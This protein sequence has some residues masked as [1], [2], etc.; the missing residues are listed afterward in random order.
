MKIKDKFSGCLIGG[1]LGDALG[2]PIEFLEFNQIKLKYGKTGLEELVFDKET[3]KALISDDTQ[4][5]L[6]TASG[7]IWAKHRIY[8][9]GIGNYVARGLYPSYMRWLY[10]QDGVMRRPELMKEQAF[11]KKDVPLLMEVHEL[12]RCR[13]PGNTCISALKSGKCGS[14]DDYINNSK[15][16]GGVM[17]VAPVGLFLHD[18]DIERVNWVGADAAAIT[19]GH[20]TGFIT[21]GLFA[22]IIAR[23]VNGEALRTA[24]TNSFT[25]LHI[26]KDFEETE[27][28][29]KLALD[30]ADSD[31]PAEEAIQEIG[32][33]WIAEEALA[34]AL[35]CALKEE[36]P[37]KA[38]LLSVNH[39]GDS[40]STGA[41]CGNT[42]GA[43]HG[44]KAFPKDW[45]DNLELS[46]FIIE[47]AD[48]LYAA[49]L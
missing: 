23:L 43:I 15:G 49:M 29:I 22:T 40:D 25:Q 24:V 17:R 41:I 10:T 9:R 30:L 46:D 4:M 32:Q 7:L 37:V 18:R 39:D 45:I 11:E 13:A 42:L 47:M 31:I 19:H 2:Y 48:R 21:A 38:L 8:H 35:Y 16:C 6:F 1:A 26:W 14:V 34:I 27:E 12:F 33:G 36:D 28:K 5:T 44:I 20:P 3:D